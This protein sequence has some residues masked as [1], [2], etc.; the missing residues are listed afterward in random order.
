MT[1]TLV[2]NIVKIAAV[3]I[4]LGFAAMFATPKGRLPLVIRN[5][6]KVLYKNREAKL[7]ENREECVPYWKRLLSFVFVIIAVLIALFFNHIG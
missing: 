7:E 2:I 5:L 4:F 6:K 1:E 3:V